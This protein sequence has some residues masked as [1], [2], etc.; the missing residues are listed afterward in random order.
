M[1]TWKK[2]FATGPVLIIGD[3]IPALQN[4]LYL[5]GRGAYGYVKGDR[6]AASAVQ[7]E[8]RRGSP[9]I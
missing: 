3:N 1:I 7:M 4:T 9:P 6:M 5:K 2:H 8:V